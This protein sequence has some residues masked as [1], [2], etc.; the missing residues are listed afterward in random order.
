MLPDRRAVIFDM[1][2]TLYPYRQYRLSGFRAVAAHLERTLGVDRR[3]AYARL[4]CASRSGGRGRELQTCLDE[5]ELGAGRLTDSSRSFVPTGPTSR[6]PA[7]SSGSS[8]RCR[9]G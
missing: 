3:I 5:W 2:D 4:L 8:G 6:C 1:D 9:A 7:S